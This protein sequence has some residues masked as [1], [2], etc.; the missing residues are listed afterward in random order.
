M[1]N[2]EPRSGL[3]VGFPVGAR[4]RTLCTGAQAPLT[5]PLP[6]SSG[7]GWCQ[8]TRSLCC[9]A[10]T[11]SRGGPLPPA[12]DE[13]AWGSTPKTLLPVM[14]G[15]R[16]Q[17]ERNFRAPTLQMARVRHNTRH[18]GCQN[19]STITLGRMSLVSLAHRG[20]AA[21][22]QLLVLGAR[23]GPERFGCC[24]SSGDLPS[25]RHAGTCRG[26]PPSRQPSARL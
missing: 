9:P 2:K 8:G 10:K 7:W 17:G 24:G 15:K 5:P 26:V 20:Q 22:L 19:P 18:L 6:S 14:G 12:E 23:D 11:P 1:L 4:S 13:G 16:I 3:L 25:Q 21:C